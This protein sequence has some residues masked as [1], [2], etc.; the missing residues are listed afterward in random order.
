MGLQQGGAEGGEGVQGVLQRRFGIVHPGVTSRFRLAPRLADDPVMG[1]DN[2]VGNGTAPFQRA[3]RKNGEAAVT[4]DIPQIAREVSLALPAQARNPVR[5]HVSQNAPVQF[6]GL[7]VFQAVQKAVHISRVP[8]DLELTQPDEARD[9]AARIFGQKGIEP[10]SHVIVQLTGDPDIDPPFSR[11]KRIRAKPLDDRDPRQ[12]GLACPAL[13]D[14]AP[15]QIRVRPSGFCGILKPGF[16]V[17]GAP[18]GEH[19]VTVDLAQ[20]GQ[21]LMPGLLAGGVAGQIVRPYPKLRGQ[22]A[23]DWQRDDLARR[24][25]PPGISKGA[26]LQRKTEAIVGAAT[27]M[28]DLQIVVC[29]RVVA[30]HRGVI[31]R[32]VEQYRPL[33]VGQ[34]AA[35]WHGDPSGNRDGRPSVRGSISGRGLGSGGR[36]G[37]RASPCLV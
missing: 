15:C 18:P 10:R 14:E 9:R 35:S 6:Q 17:P 16:Q 33:A 7:Q 37:N 36:Q 19:L 21:V 28:D 8:P 11:D 13:L 2:G 4:R 20:D 30:Q 1:L 34:N 23:C 24:Q 12:N 25:Q 5:R 27:G 3:D 26:E 29:Q 31:G 22:K 32:Q